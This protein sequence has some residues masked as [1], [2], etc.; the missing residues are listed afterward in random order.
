MKIIIIFFLIKSISFAQNINRCQENAYKLYRLHKTFA[1][2]RPQ[3]DSLF[4][5]INSTIPIEKQV[6]LDHEFNQIIDFKYNKSLKIKNSDIRELVEL[7]RSGK[8]YYNSMSDVYLD[9][10][11]KK[12]KTNVQKV[13]ILGLYDIDYLPWIE[14][15]LLNLNPSAKIL[16]IDYQLKI[17]QTE[18]I[19]W[20]HLNEF[21]DMALVKQN[22]E[23]F[24]L[25][26]NY[27]MI[28]KVGLGRYGEEISIDSD[29]DTIDFMNCILK[30]NGLVVLSMSWNKYGNHSYVGFN[31]GRLYHE[32]RLNEI[33]KNFEILYESFYNFGSNLILVM[34]KIFV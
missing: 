25:V 4:K 14:A 2:K 17:Y 31:S 30:K 27:M 32:D 12:F 6:L 3:F 16:V 15:V 23:Q 21:L 19:N 22:F 10:T 26:I 9:E 5:I 8:T 24:D 29:L 1:Q 11:L 33:K 13:A 34:K 7:I 28:E 18:N 20:I